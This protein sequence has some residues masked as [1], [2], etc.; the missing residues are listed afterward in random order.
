VLRIPA[1]LA[2]WSLFVWGV[3]IRNAE[4]ELG[5]TSLAVSFVVLAVAVLAT[6]G[7]RLPT[8]ALAGWTIA[9]WVLRAFDIALLSDHEVGFVVVHTVLA[10]VSIVLGVLA[11]RAVRSST[12]PRLSRVG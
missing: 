5:P 10:A 11:V 1:A 7:A 8:L 9:V 12:S 6:R 4:G 2:L 3:R